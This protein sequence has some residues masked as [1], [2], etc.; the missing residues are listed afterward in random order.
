LRTETPY[1]PPTTTPP[2]YVLRVCFQVDHRDTLF[3][4]HRYLRVFDGIVVAVLVVRTKI[5]YG[6]LLFVTSGTTF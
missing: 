1:V 4:I 5:D 3:F 6:I 2:P